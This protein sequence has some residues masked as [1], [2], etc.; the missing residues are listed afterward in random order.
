MLRITRC[1]R[2]R[3]SLPRPSPKT[4]NSSSV[5]TLCYL[6]ASSALHH[7]IPPPPQTTL[8]QDSEK[9]AKQRSTRTHDKHNPGAQAQS[10]LQIAPCS[11]PCRYGRARALPTQP[12]AP[13]NTLNANGRLNVH[14]RYPITVRVAPVVQTATHNLKTYVQTAARAPKTCGFPGLEYEAPLDMCMPP[15]SNLSPGMAQRWRQSDGDLKIG[16]PARHTGPLAVHLNRQLP[17][18]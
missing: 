4:G 2:C 17:P 6:P 9:N 18:S 8:Q 15:K 10:L 3:C 7:K 1:C 13:A 12:T 14:R 16:P 5:L 11:A